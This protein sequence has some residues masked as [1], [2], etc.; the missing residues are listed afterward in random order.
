[1]TDKTTAFPSSKNLSS[2]F[3]LLV[4]GLLTLLPG[5]TLS[6][7]ASQETPM[8]AGKEAEANGIISNTAQLQY[9]AEPLAVTLTT[10]E[11]ATRTIT[12]ENVGTQ[13]L[14]YSLT[15]LALSSPETNAFS[16]NVQSA[17]GPMQLEPEVGAN[18]AA[19]GSGGY[20]IYLRQ[21]PD[22]SRAPQLEWQERGRFVVQAL[23][24]TAQ[25]SQAS[26]RAYL[27]RQ[28]VS[29]QSFWVD[30]V[31]AVE[32]STYETFLGLTSQPEIWAIRARR[33]PRLYEPQAVEPPTITLASLEANLTHLQVD[34]VW[35]ELGLTG[36]GMTVAN[37]DTGVR[38]TH[39]ALVEKYRGNH[40]EDF[41]HDYNWWDPYAVPTAPY[42]KHGHGTH[43]MGIMT[44]D[45]GESN[46]IGMAP[47][48]E[49]I[50]CA[51]F[52]SDGSCTD[53]GL[54]ECG[55]FMVAPW[56]LEGEEPNPD[57]RPIVVN[58]SWG[59]CARSIDPWYQDVV[60]AWQ[61]AG[62]Y[63]VFSN[64][65]A[66]NCGYSSPPG[67]NTVGNPAR[68][69]NVSGVGSTGTSDG[70]YAPH[71]N[72]GPTDATDTLNPR[73]YTHLKP[74][75]LAPGTARSSYRG[76]D[77]TYAWMRGT[78]MASPHLSG[79]IALLWEA[80]PCLLGNYAK[81][82]TLVEQTAN[83]IPYESGYG[84]EG[85]GNVPNYATGW[86]EINAY[87]AVQA[88][89]EYCNQ[90]LPWL[91][92]VPITG[93]I[94]PASSE[95]IA[96]I[97]T[98]GQ[99]AIG[100]YTGALQLNQSAAPRNP[101]TF[102]VTMTV[103]HAL[104]VTAVPTRSTQ[105]GKAESNVTYPLTL[106]NTG[107]VTTTYQFTPHQNNWLTSIQPPTLTLAI[108]ATAQ[109]TV[110]VQIPDKYVLQ[111]KNFDVVTITISTESDPGFRE[112]IQLTTRGLAEWKYYFPWMCIKS[113]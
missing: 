9:T 64:G 13:T 69:G 75:V 100:R 31:I 101:I 81:T 79:L 59:D 56:N 104:S 23:Q 52:M 19:A 49:W 99:L 89:I 39:Q 78:S 112:Y 113:D 38:Y 30:N 57:L 44:G 25:L 66:G 16:I 14:T 77:S 27:E 2:F 58:N 12:L 17:S 91:A 6:A 20:L 83:P 93:Q 109:S 1:M 84:D 35:N 88:A 55:Q 42:D 65:N 53:T 60:N 110:T 21:Q 29:Y 87:A 40:G 45:D 103:T 15:E 80:A 73:G 47:G 51:G 63:P 85:P 96:V 32:N 97:F 70:A 26:I 105:Q 36:T 7:V 111:D 8:Q 74:Q 37:I 43:T 28:G 62:I 67:L 4:I 68:Y 10:G 86:G 95:E 72:W 107:D 54:L 61:A 76:S 41:E 48:A 90:D 106:T 94:A 11:Q 102:P 34:R 108:A 22:L 18:L 92:T 71:S 5:L 98:S 3:V 82:E 50:A 33:Q 46:Q 24:E